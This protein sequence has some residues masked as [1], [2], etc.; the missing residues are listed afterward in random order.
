MLGWKQQRDHALLAI[1]QMIAAHAAHMN[2]IDAALG[3]L[4]MGPRPD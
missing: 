3:I 4:F 1:S 2:Q